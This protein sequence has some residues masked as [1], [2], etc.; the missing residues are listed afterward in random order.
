VVTTTLTSALAQSGVVAGAELLLVELG[1][2]VELDGLLDGVPGGVVLTV[3]AGVE[4]PACGDPEDRP[5]NSHHS[6]ATTRITPTS[7]SAR[8]TQ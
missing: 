4:G 2:D 1:W 5:R 3:D 8:R 6:S 7:T